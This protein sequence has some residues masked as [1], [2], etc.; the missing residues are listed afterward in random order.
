MIL[1]KAEIFVLEKI[2]YQLNHISFYSFFQFFELIIKKYFSI[3]L[4]QKI[5]YIAV[6]I[7]KRLIQTKEL[8]FNLTPL[9]QIMIILN[10]AFLLLQQLNCLVIS[11]YSEF[12]K[13]LS[14]ITMNQQF[15]C[16][17]KYSSILIKNLRL[18]NEFIDRIN[19]IQ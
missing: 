15:N 1:K 9:E 10:T 5:H 8:Y 6:Y 17:E 11:D 19:N 4:Q 12:F 16:F 18:S 7:M 13:E 3:P 14:N 2:N